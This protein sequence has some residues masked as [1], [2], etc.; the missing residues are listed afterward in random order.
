LIAFEQTLFVLVIVNE[1]FSLFSMVA[2]VEGYYEASGAPP[3]DVALIL[4]LFGV[5]FSF[6]P[7]AAPNI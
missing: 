7:L 6:F 1:S 3:T 5:A 4:P 2:K